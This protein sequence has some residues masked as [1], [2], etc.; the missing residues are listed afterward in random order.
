[1]AVETIIAAQTGAATKTKYMAGN[2]TSKVSFTATNL[3]TTET[4]TPYVGGGAGWTPLYDSSG[5]QLKLT[6]TKPQLELPGGCHYAFD[7]DATAGAASL[8]ASPVYEQ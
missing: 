8:E 4:I 1:V 3:A 5:T 2:K 7:K 6:A